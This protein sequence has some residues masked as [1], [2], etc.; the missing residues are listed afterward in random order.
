M[1]YFQRCVEWE[2]KAN[3]V[4][5]VCHAELH[6]YKDRSCVKCE[7]GDVCL[8]CIQIFEPTRLEPQPPDQTMNRN[9]EFDQSPGKIFSSGKSLLSEKVLSAVSCQCSHGVALAKAC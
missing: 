3:D 1:V 6:G 7:S 5:Y 2:L 9:L 8:D 4:C